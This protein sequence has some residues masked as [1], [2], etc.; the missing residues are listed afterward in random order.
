MKRVAVLALLWC[1][2]LLV[3]SSCTPKNQNRTYD[4]Q[5]VITETAELIQKSDLINRIFWGTGIPVSEAEDAL[6]KGKYTEADPVFL[7]QNGITS[8]EKL[9]EMTSLVYDSVF[10][11]TIFETKLSAVSDEEI[12][13]VSY[14]RYYQ[15]SE[16]VADAL[17]SAGPI[18]V[19]TESIVYFEKPVVYHT[20]TLTIKEVKGDIIYLTLDVT[21]L[22]DLDRPVIK[23]L[24]VAV[25]EESAGWRLINP[26]YDKYVSNQQH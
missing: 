6:K 12:G 10:C 9:K 17:M 13:V 1:T 24:T 3:L 25:I 22:D 14:V 16:K 8:I 7:E 26:T 23:Q 20:D 18:M 21:V 15:E 19:H 5:T 11:K 2:A 4:E